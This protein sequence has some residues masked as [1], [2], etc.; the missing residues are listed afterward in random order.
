M[1]LATLHLQLLGPWHPGTGRGEGPGA[2]AIVNTDASGLPFLP[3]RTLKGLLRD[4][5]RLAVAAGA[6]DAGLLDRLFGHEGAG[7]EDATRYR[8]VA[9]ALHLTSA[10]VG[11]DP[12]D[13]AAW[14][15]WAARNHDARAQLFRT[16]ASTRLDERGVAADGTLRTIQVAIPVP[17]VATAT[18][19]DGSGVPRSDALAALKTIAPL[20]Y[21]VGAHRT[22]GLGRC[23]VTVKEA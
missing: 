18:L 6:L 15:A 8:T 5:A 1:P 23:I 12:G 3:G 19:A 16:V 11:E 22:R 7:G 10:T 2:D 17:L 9:G 4:G 20:I 21:A 13:A 14:Q